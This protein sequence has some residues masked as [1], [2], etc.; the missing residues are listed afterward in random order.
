MTAGFVGAFA[1]I[2]H[3]YER[4]VFDALKL[5]LIS[6]AVGIAFFILVMFFSDFWYFLNIA[7]SILCAIALWE[8]FVATNYIKNLP[9]L[10]VSE[11]FVVSIPFLSSP[12]FNIEISL[13]VTLAFIVA[14]II[15]MLAQKNSTSIEQIGLV[16]MM[17]LLIPFA[18]SSI[19]F[20]RDVPYILDLE[21]VDGLFF[22]V[23]A[24]IGAWVTDAGGYFAGLLFGK[25]KMAPK[26][27]PKK[28][29]EGAVGAVLFCIIGF[30]IAGFVYQN[31][32]LEDGGH[33]NIVALAIIALLCAAAAMLGDLA[34]SFIKRS[35]NIKDFG[36]IM[37]GHGGILYR[38]DS[39]LLVAPLMYVIILFVPIVV[40]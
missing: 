5:R 10:I 2:F 21:P 26:I 7:I 36:Q 35:F 19:I 34:A 15:I 37:P 18:F 24:G 17:S 31:V 8:I 25:H 39:L 9:L 16:F 38:F 14:L 13:A 23:L 33:V 22:I 3:G 6:G 20:L 30:I 27:S 40:R 11:L 4:E 29:W 12:F 28:T 1:R 32:F